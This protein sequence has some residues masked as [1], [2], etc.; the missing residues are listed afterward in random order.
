MRTAGYFLIAIV[1]LAASLV[2]VTKA[3]EVR[4][5][6]FVPLVA[7]GFVGV[8]LVRVG[9]RSHAQAAHRV[10]ANVQSLNTSLA[11]IVEKVSRLNRDKA[12]IDTYDMRQ[13]LDEMLLEDLDTFVEARESI[14]H[15]YGLQAYADV[16]SHFAAGERYVNR[17]WS[18]SA[19]GYIDEVNAYLDKAEEQFKEARERLRGLGA[20]GASVA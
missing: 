17:V 14:G 13:R 8:A 16:M 20:A 18:A 1:F 5:G 2:A 3:L 6:Y 9:I 7:L 15:Q 11:S 19:D 4:W 10:T 12:S